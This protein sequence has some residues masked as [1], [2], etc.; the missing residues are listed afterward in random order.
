MLSRL[1]RL[2]FH[3]GGR[4]PRGLARCQ[5]TLTLSKVSVPKAR[6]VPDSEV[7]QEKAQKAWHALPSLAEPHAEHIDHIAA[8]RAGC[9]VPAWSTG[10]VVH[11][12]GGQ[13]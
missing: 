11:G 12:A 3:F 8:A 10:R 2:A 6:L 5:L 13:S 7:K 1:R 9:R 4:L